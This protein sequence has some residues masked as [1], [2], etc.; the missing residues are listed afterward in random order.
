MV[1]TSG[2]RSN[3]QYIQGPRIFFTTSNYADV[4]DDAWDLLM[5]LLQQLAKN[6]R[7]TIEAAEGYLLTKVRILFTTRSAIMLT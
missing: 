1:G 3:K 6:W 5:P 7:N 4:P 2:T